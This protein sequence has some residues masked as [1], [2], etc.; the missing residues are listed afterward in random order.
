M[1]SESAAATATQT[2]PMTGDEYLESLRDGREIWLYGER[3]ADVTTHPGFRNTARMIA[4]LYDALHDP[5]Y[6]DVLTTETDTGSGGYTHRYFRVPQT[7]E[8]QLAGRD[9]IAAWAR[10]TYGFLGRAPDY[11][12]AFLGTLGANAAFYKPFDANARAWYKKSQERVLFLNHAI[13][14]PPVDRD[15]PIHERAEVCVHA[16]KETD[17]GIYVSGAKIVATGSALTNATFVAHNGLIPLQDRQYA[18]VFMVPMNAP[19]VKL[20]SRAS[21]E[22]AA[23]VMG[24]PFDYPLS[25]RLDENDAV[26]VLDNVFIPWEDV[27]VYGDVDAANNFFPQTGFLPRALLHGC[28]RLAVKLEFIAGLMMKALEATGTKDYRGQQVRTGEVIAYRNL[29]WS[30]SEAMARNAEPWVNGAVLPNMESG[31]AFWTFG[32]TFYPIVKNLIE[33]SVTSGLIY[34]NSSAKDFHNPE[35]RP[36]LDTYLRGTGAYDAEQRVK[37]MKLLWDSIGTEF[38]GRGELYEINWS[39]STEE[40]RI[41]TLGIA[42]ATGLAGRMKEFVEGCMAEYNLDGWTVPDLIDPDDISRLPARS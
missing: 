4:R 5:K 15:R 14:H 10:L 3:V 32:A 28:T 16:T 8:E 11:K 26:F 25:S 41:S 30:L 39:G 17:A 37:L 12:A 23:A 35:L 36:Y 40:T 33:Q 20:I 42:Q 6:K 19:G 9:A 38:G 1:T 13:I 34:L 2:R 24:T 27:F 21:Y 31:T 7:W 29:F 22:N 18:C